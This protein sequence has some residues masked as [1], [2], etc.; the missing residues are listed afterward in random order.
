M[1]PSVAYR[2]SLRLPHLPLRMAEHSRRAQVFANRLRER[3]V[4]VIYP[5]LDGHP[6]RELLA[7]IGNPAYG[8]GGIF[9]VDLGDTVRANRF[10]EILQNQEQFGFMAVSLGYFETLMSCSSASTASEMPPEHQAR[11]GIMPGLVR[12]SIGYTGSLEQRWTQMEGALR[13]MSLV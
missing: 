2:I 8:Y 13:A 5:G 1:D 11:A 10:M 9:A 3:G 12:I 4:P 6:D 7:R